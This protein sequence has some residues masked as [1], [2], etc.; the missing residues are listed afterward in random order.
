MEV[1]ADRP[2]L[3]DVRTTTDPSKMLPGVDARTRQGAQ[4]MSPKRGLV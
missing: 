1:Q 4:V 3:I 2:V